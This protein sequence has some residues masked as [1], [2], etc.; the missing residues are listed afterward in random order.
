MLGAEARGFI[1]GA[2][3]RV[4]ARLRL[5]RRAAAGQAAA[6][7]RSARPTRSST[8]R[9]RSSCTPTRSAT[10]ARVLIHDDVLATGGTVEAIVGL[11]EQLGGEVVGVVLH[12][13]ADVPRAAASGSSSYDLHSLIDVLEP[14]AARRCLRVRTCRLQRLQGM[15]DA[16]TE[17]VHVRVPDAGRG[18]RARSRRSA[19]SSGCP[20]PRTRRVYRVDVRVRLRRRARR[21]RRARRARLGAARPRG[22]ARSST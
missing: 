13:R 7:R 14:R 2:R 1:L 19:R 15:Y 6:A 16:L 18:A 22:R 11:V 21:P 4:R 8:A 3:D 5:R 17:P 20:A 10:G 12:H 9:T